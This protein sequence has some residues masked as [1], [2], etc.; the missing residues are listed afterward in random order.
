[1]DI[2]E[3][4]C[5]ALV[6]VFRYF[7]VIH[8]WF[9]S[10]TTLVRVRPLTNDA[11]GENKRKGWKT[12]AGKFFKIK[13]KFYSKE[14]GDTSLDEDM[15]ESDNEEMFFIWIEHQGKQ[16]KEVPGIEAKIDYEGE[17]I[18]ALDDLQEEREKNK[19][20]TNKINQLKQRIE[21]SG[22]VRQGLF[23]MRKKIREAKETNGRLIS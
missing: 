19:I 12:N 1:M 9:E 17:L 5:I 20:L 7:L 18:S 10:Q 16:R 8:I 15:D 22:E 3:G 4:V 2:S 6:T 14:E 11:T 21:G 23:H 13:N